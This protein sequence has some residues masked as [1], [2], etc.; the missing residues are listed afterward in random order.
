MPEEPRFH[1]LEPSGA[2]ED[3]A[4]V[5]SG[6]ASDGGDLD[7]R[8]HVAL[9]MVS[10]TD[11]RATIDGRAGPIGNEAD[12]RLFHRLRTRVDAVM[13]GAR[14]VALERYGRLV[15]DPDLREERRRVGLEPDPLA[16]IVSGRLDL[17][18]DVP[19][20][21]D[22]DSRVVIVTGSDGELGGC[23]ARVEYLRFEGGTL[24]LAPALRR[25]RQEYGIR[26]VLCEGGPGLNSTLLREGVVDELFLSLA[27]KL[28]GGPDALTIVSGLPMSGAAELELVSARLADSDLF[29]RYRVSR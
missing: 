25:L 18:A 17:P 29:L 11:G 10:T 13:A 15:R 28:V 5:A 12:R 8:P 14:T 27:A 20:L 2:P 7:D 19:L 9:N 21:Q 4:Q 22:E 16:V 6:L 23:R 26:S 3:A 1:R 24:E